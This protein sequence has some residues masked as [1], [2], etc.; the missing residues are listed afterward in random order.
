MTVFAIYKRAFTAEI[1]S[2]GSIW[3]PKCAAAMALATPKKYAISAHSRVLAQRNDGDGAMPDDRF[4][5]ATAS[6]TLDASPGGSCASKPGRM[7][8]SLTL[9]L[10]TQM[11]G[12]ARR[13]QPCQRAA[14]ATDG[15]IQHRI[16]CTS[17][18]LHPG[19][20]GPLHRPAG[21]GLLC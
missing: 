1:Q 14:Y 3:L 20:C 7:D 21:A 18:R 19:I 16:F 10:V 8:A 13:R 2:I 6:N 11:P 15:H 5:G 4:V 17:I 9:L 12:F